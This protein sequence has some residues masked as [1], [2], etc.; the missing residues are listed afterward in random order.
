MLGCYE[1]E[2]SFFVKIAHR[3]S[4]FAC[5]RLCK[6]LAL[7]VFSDKLISITLRTKEADNILH[8]CPSSLQIL[9][10]KRLLN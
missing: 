7:A 6:D 10:M 4:F 8:C 9:I 2:N 5:L 1:T 3:L